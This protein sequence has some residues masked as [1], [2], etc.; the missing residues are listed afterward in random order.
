[1][2]QHSRGGDPVKSMVQ[3]NKL[4]EEYLHLA[5][6]GM[7]ARIP[8][9]TVGWR[10]QL[11]PR[12][13]KFGR[14]AGDR[15]VLLNLLSNAFYAVGER[16]ERLRSSDEVYHPEVRVSTVSLSRYVALS[17]G[18]NGTSIPATVRERIFEPFFTT[19]ATGQGT[20]LGLSI[21]YDI[22]KAHGGE[23]KVETEEGRG[24]IFTLLLPIA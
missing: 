2:L 18:D 1:M 23:M 14:A 19:K 20:G 6:H 17:V 22:V 3:L 15:A 16:A 5:Y 7:R 4:A 8:V 13:R 12:F 21:S 9:S 10:K 11:D 24:T